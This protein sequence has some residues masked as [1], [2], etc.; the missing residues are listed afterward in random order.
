MEKVHCDGNCKE[1][2]LVD[3]RFGNSA[4]AHLI[5][6]LSNPGKHIYHNQENSIGDYLVSEDGADLNMSAEVNNW[7][8][9]MGNSLL[10]GK[11]GELLVQCILE[12]WGYKVYTP[13]V[14]DHGIDMIAIDTKGE[15]RE[16]KIQVKTVK[17]G[18]YCFIRESN[19]LSD[20]N[21]YVFYIRVSQNGVPSVYIYPA[22]LWPEK[23]KKVITRSENGQFTYHPYCGDDQVSKAEYGISGAA[24]YYKIEDGHRLI[25]ESAWSY[26]R[27]IL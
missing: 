16:I 7:E 4:K 5:A 23:N 8:K 10:L 24:K 18:H 12:E 26:K 20:E 19:F 2:D 22:E 17:E 6:I 15:K 21:F 27:A 13:L 25:P 1:I 14:D 9:I 3:N 11:C